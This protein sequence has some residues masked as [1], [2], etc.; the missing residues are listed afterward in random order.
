[1]ANGSAVGLVGGGGGGGVLRMPGGCGMAAHMTPEQIS[2]VV[3]IKPEAITRLLGKHAS[4]R[5]MFF[6]VAKLGG[7]PAP[8]LWPSRLNEF[9]AIVDRLKLR[10]ALTEADYLP[11]RWRPLDPQTAERLALQERLTAP[12]DYEPPQVR[13]AYCVEATVQ[14]LADAAANGP[15]PAAP[16]PKPLPP[17]CEILLKHGDNPALTDEQAVEAARVEL[18]ANGEDIDA[19]TLTRRLTGLRAAGMLPAGGGHA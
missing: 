1:M 5:G 7:S 11:E 3:G 14:D 8:A 12:L 6:E 18:A 4:L 13:P 10:G 2:N 15:K 17:V 9:L 16:A 19:A